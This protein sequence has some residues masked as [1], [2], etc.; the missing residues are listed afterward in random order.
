M[1]ETV[2]GRPSPS[3]STWATIRQPPTLTHA[4]GV[5]RVAAAVVVAAPHPRWTERPLALFI[6]QGEA[7]SAQELREHLAGHVAKWW[8]PDDFLAV[9]ELPIGATGKFLKRDIREQHKNHVWSGEAG[10]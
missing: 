4:A 5:A 6:P 9:A 1:V 2:S 7:P 3:T 10:A 8:I